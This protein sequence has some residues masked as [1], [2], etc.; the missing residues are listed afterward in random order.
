MKATRYHM[1]KT[2]GVVCVTV[3]HPGLTP[4]FVKHTDRK[5]PH[6]YVRRKTQEEAEKD[7]IP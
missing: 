2:A 4:D 7:P 6:G 1:S 3:S 5:D